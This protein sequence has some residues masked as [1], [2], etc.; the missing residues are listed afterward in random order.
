MSEERGKLPEGLPRWQ[1]RYYV[2][3]SCRSRC[4]LDET[5]LRDLFAFIKLKHEGTSPGRRVE[6]HSPG[7]AVDVC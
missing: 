6:L 4:P 2:Q 5:P 3:M 7:V 1:C